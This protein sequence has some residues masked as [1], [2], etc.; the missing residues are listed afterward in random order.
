MTGCMATWDGARDDGYGVDDAAAGE[1]AD[2]DEE[3][4]HDDDFDDR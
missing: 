1:E 4:E 3:E 2:D